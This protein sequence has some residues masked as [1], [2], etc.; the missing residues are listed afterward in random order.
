MS[1][2]PFEGASNNRDDDNGKVFPDV[3]SGSPE[4]THREDISP[5]STAGAEN[6][7]HSEFTSVIDAPQHSTR[8]KTHS[9]EEMGSNGG[10][11]CYWTK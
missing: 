7:K 10:G 11:F 2:Q 9:E 5:E 8:D 3:I 1:L 4:N 6:I